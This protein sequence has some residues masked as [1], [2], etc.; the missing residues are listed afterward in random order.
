MHQ[1]VGNI[2]RTILHTNPPQD[3]ANANAMVDYALQLAIY[4]MRTTVH[5]TLGIAPGSLVFHRDM[6]MDLPFVAD[7]LLLRNKRQELI[8]YNLR[9]ENYKRRTFDYQPGQWILELIPNPTKTGLRT[10]G[11]YQIQ[12]VHCNGTITI[13]RT[14]NITDRLH[15]RQ[16]RPFF[17]AEE[18]NFHGPAEP[19]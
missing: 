14:A 10:K 2:L 6:I 16:V 18:G 7:L 13:R 8:D 4:A 3:E 15:I 5:R 11:P 12:R 9:R 19:H 17:L 1:V